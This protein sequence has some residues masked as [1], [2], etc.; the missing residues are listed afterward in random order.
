MTIAT[1]S[2][3]ET[4]I[5]RTQRL[6]WGILLMIAPLTVLLMLG[7]PSSL[8][9]FN[10]RYSWI[11]I[12]MIGGTL[13]ILFPI[14]WLAQRQQTL[15]WR[16]SR[17]S[18][19]DVAVERIY[20][21][22]VETILYTTITQVTIWETRRA[23]VH[24]LNIV[25]P[26]TTFILTGY[27]GLNRLSHELLGHLT[28]NQLVRRKP[29]RFDALNPW[30]FGG[31]ILLLIGLLVGCVQTFG[32]DWFFITGIIQVVSALTFLFARPQ[33]KMLGKQRR[34]TEIVMAGF[35]LLA[36]VAMFVMLLAREGAA[37]LWSNPCST[38]RRLDWAGGCVRVLDESEYAVFTNQD[39]EVVRSFNR[40]ISQGTLNAW[41][42]LWTPIWLDDG[43]V[44]G[45]NAAANRQRIAIWR[46]TETRRDD[47]E[48]WDVATQSVVYQYHSYAL[49]VNA[50]QFALSPDGT[51]LAV[52][53]YDDLTLWNIAT[54]QILWSKEDAS[55]ETVVFSPDGKYVVV[56]QIAET[57]TKFVFYD[58]QS[59]LPET[60]LI[61]PQ[62]EFSAGYDFDMHI[63]PDGRWL[64]AFSGAT[65]RLMVWDLTTGM[66]AQQ[67][68][69]GQL[70]RL[71]VAMSFSVDSQYLIAGFE[72]KKANG[73]MGNRLTFWRLADATL[74]QE[75]LLGER[76][77]TRIHALDVSPDGNQLAVGTYD[78]TFI[79][80][81][82]ELL[83]RE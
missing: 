65:G 72:D 83:D 69:L 4:H 29:L 60:I 70:T 76:Y 39:D 26:Q 46:K 67:L 16:A 9:L 11:F 45:M 41:I 27:G 43:Q 13:A 54:D 47:I 33:S 55:F 14:I 50:S 81:I 62:E 42:G 64:V 82:D 3:S 56:G 78:Q 12:I 77:D 36:A 24:T 40:G 66:I 75:I 17:V 58:L 10:N 32:G 37:A 22:Q 5:R 53:D 79:F 71:N 35:L 59:G 1:F 7:S 63:S 73:Q 38:I 30:H 31:L 80:E 18:L 52:G 44:Q 49:I 28:P 8:F 34:G 6:L 74:I 23:G 21:Q 61:P 2:P 68:V 48:V 51:I 20:H 57:Q 19:T 25:S 15:I